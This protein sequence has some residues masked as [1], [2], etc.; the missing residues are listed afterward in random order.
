MTISPRVSAIPVLSAAGV[1][2][3]GLSSMR[4]RG[5]RE[6]ISRMRSRVPSSLMPSTTTTCNMPA[7]YSHRR[8]DLRHASMWGPSFRHGTTTLTVG[9][10]ASTI[11]P[12]RDGC[13]C[14]GHGRRGGQGMERAADG[15]VGGGE[16]DGGGPEHPAREHAKEPVVDEIRGAFDERDVQ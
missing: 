1:T 6:A 16:P 3:D 2:F 8:M 4:T 15:H 9:S 13:G 14:R 5:S 7:G 10:A 11:G 12:P